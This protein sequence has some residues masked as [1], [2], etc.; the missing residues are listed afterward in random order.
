MQVLFTKRKRKFTTFTDVQVNLDD[1]IL[2][3]SGIAYL[4]FFSSFFLCI[5]INVYAYSLQFEKW[6]ELQQV[7]ALN[8]KA[9]RKEKLL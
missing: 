1:V 5:Y 6:N 4:Y 3:L 8:K 9:N 7:K 2:F